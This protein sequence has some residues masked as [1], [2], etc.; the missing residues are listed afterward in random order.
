MQYAWKSCYLRYIF[1]VILLTKSVNSQ[2]FSLVFLHELQHIKN[3]D[4]FFRLLSMLAILLHCYNLFIYLFFRELKEVQELHCDEQLVVS[5][6]PEEKKRYGDLLLQIGSE[7]FTAHSSILYFSKKR[8]KNFMR[9]RIFHLTKPNSKKSRLLLTFLTVCM[10]GSAC[11]PVAAYSPV[12]IDWRHKED[13]IL[14]FDPNITWIYIANPET[15]T[16]IEVAED[17]INFKYADAYVILENGEIVLITQ[18]ADENSSRASC[19]HNYVSAVSKTH[20]KSPS[21]G[22]TVSTYDSLFCTKCRNVVYQDLTG[23][24]YFKVCPH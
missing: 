22:C 6:T 12:T 23:L 15:E 14:S 19:S 21:G 7:D 17:E 5:F 20:S 10:V 2:D 11:I 16:E 1:S 9:K 18:N 24:Q 8:R 4:F 3:H 13:S